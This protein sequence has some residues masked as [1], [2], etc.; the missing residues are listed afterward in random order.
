MNVFWGVCVLHG[1]PLGD[2]GME[3]KMDP[4]N[5]WGAIAVGPDNQE[6]SS[7]SLRECLKKPPLLSANIAEAAKGCAPRWGDGRGGR[8]LRG[9]R[10]VA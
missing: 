10:H 4:Q 5:N 9:V 3:S 7:V 6:R 8:S 1:T 2:E